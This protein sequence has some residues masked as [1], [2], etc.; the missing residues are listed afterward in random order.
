MAK[1]G[2]A[3]LSRVDLIEQCQVAYNDLIDI[4]GRAAIQAELQLSA[5]EAAG[6]SQ[7][8]GKRARTTWFSTVARRARCF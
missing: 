8:Q 1:N 2:L 7:P 5:I 6:G 4:T 3:L